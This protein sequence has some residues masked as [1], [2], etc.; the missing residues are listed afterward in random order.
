MKEIFIPTE[1]VDKNKFP[2]ELLPTPDEI[3]KVRKWAH[4]E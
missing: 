3:E 4:R 2:P 1:D